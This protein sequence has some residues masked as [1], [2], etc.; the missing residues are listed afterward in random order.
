MLRRWGLVSCI[1]DVTLD[2]KNPVTGTGFLN[3]LKVCV[4]FL[5]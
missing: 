1:F 3:F 5:R 4:R 2:T